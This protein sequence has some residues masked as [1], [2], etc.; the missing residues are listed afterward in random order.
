MTVNLKGGEKMNAIAM[1]V[2]QM[3][4]PVKQADSIKPEETGQNHALFQSLLDGS[5]T[6]EILPD[7]QE[8]EENNEKGTNPLSYS[9]QMLVEHIPADENT[10]TDGFTK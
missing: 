7:Q 10:E 4:L 5:L 1:F 6:G 3:Q 8:G 9:L 2:Q